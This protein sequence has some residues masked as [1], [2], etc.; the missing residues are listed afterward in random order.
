MAKETKYICHIYRKT[1]KGQ[2]VI[3]ETIECRSELAAEMRAEKI[4]ESGTHEGVD[5]VMLA[6]D[7]ELGEYDEPVFITR[8]G[9][10]PDTE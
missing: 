6:A 4:W 5:A 10:V 8:F 9:V 2:L 7:P 1:N 3:D